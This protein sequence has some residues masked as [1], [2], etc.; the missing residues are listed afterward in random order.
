[1]KATRATNKFL[2]DLKRARK[3]GKDLAKL[4]AIVALI[5][6]GAKLDPKFRTHKL[7][8][9]FD[10]YWECHVEP[11]WLLIWD[12]QDTEIVLMGCG[13]HADLFE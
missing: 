13:T 10:G 4:E 2:R 8:G 12:D 1:M 6:N 7:R 3:R 5:A 11:D 9:E